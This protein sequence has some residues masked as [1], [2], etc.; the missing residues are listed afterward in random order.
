[1]D[2]SITS[3]ATRRA[4]R[5]VIYVH[6]EVFPDGNDASAQCDFVRRGLEMR[7]ALS[8]DW[9]LPT[10]GVA[11]GSA[12]DVLEALAGMQDRHGDVFAVSPCTCTRNDSSEQ[13]QSGATTT[14]NTSA[15]AGDDLLVAL[16]PRP[17]KGEH[18]ACWDYAFWH[19]TCVRVAPELLEA[20]RDGEHVQSVIASCRSLCALGG[21]EASG[22]V[23]H[24]PMQSRPTVAQVLLDVNHKIGLAAKYG[25]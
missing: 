10:F 17:H 16:W 14:M 9:C 4:K 15:T 18:A 25:S 19:P 8:L 13:H 12:T 23:I 22:G 7:A 3:S 24:Q 11:Q 2:N 6:H 5:T 21:A 20:L 1:M